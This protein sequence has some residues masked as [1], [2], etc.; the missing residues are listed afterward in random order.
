M[1]SLSLL[2]LFNLCH[3][4]SPPFY[5]SEEQIV[6]VSSKSKETN[7]QCRP[8]IEGCTEFAIAYWLA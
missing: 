8:K 2:N 5:P 7:E 3:K 6:A 1:S 4:L